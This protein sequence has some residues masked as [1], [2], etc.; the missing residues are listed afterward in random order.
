[1]KNQENISDEYMEQELINLKSNCGI[2]NICA[3]LEFNKIDNIAP[4]NEVYLKNSLKRFYNAKIDGIV[5]SWDL[6]SIPHEHLMAYI[7]SRQ[8]NESKNS[9]S[10]G[11]CK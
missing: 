1:M 8:Q 3:G 2:K 4:S 6:M 7:E 9:D 5:L 10:G 11:G